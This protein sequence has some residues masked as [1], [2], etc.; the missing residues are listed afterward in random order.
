M[1]TLLALDRILAAMHKTIIE[2]LIF[3]V[4]VMV[5]YGYYYVMFKVWNPFP[6]GLKKKVDNVSWTRVIIL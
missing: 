1:G 5:G 3:E 2:Q 6:L 4:R